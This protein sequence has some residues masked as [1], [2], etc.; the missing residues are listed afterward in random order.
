MLPPSGKGKSITLDWHH[1]LQ[2]DAT[3]KLKLRI[4][5]KGTEYRNSEETEEVKVSSS[6]KNAP[7][8][9]V[10]EESVRMESRPCSKPEIMCSKE[11]IIICTWFKWEDGKCRQLACELKVYVQLSNK[12][13]HQPG[14]SEF[15]NLIPNQQGIITRCHA[16]HRFTVDYVIV[17]NQICKRSLPTLKEKQKDQMTH[18]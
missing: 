13:L 14:V 15:I 3:S 12:T 4:I 10:C 17:W 8:F 9:G 1:N 16:H 2:C 5:R 11:K 18:C 7:N 6:S